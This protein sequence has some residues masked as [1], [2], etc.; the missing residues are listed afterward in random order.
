MPIWILEEKDGL[1]LV[2][3]ILPPGWEGAKP[4][5]PAGADLE[6][7]IWTE[8]IF[9]AAYL[10]CELCRPHLAGAS[11]NCGSDPEKCVQDHI[12]DGVLR[13]LHR[14]ASRGTDSEPVLSARERRLDA[15]LARFEGHRGEYPDLVSFRESLLAAV[16]GA[17]PPSCPLSQPLRLQEQLFR[18]RSAW[19][20]GRGE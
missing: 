3:V 17:A 7:E 20:A 11:R 13:R 12:V 4:V 19:Y 9:T 2:Y 15:A 14:R 1:P 6:D 8:P 16:G 18:R 5:F 10:I